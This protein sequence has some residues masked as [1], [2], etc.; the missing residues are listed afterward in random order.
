M[1][2]PK[3]RRNSELFYN[4]KWDN[5]SKH[6]FFSKYAAHS[7]LQLS[8][9]KGNVLAGNVLAEQSI[10]KISLMLGLI[11][12]STYLQPQDD[13]ETILYQFVIIK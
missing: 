3:L 4:Y 7:S 10:N 11:T 2:F 13:S 1:Y 8:K 5:M 9:P 6:R 12:H